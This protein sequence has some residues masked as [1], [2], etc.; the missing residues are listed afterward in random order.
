MLGAI[1]GDIV[2]SRYEARDS[3]MLSKDFPLFDS[4]CRFTDDTVMTLATAEA[5]IAG[6]DDEGQKS[7]EMKFVSDVYKKW[8]KKFPDR[9]YGIRTRMWY[10]S[11]DIIS[12]KPSFANGAAMRIS[13]AAWF[14]GTLK[15]TQAKAKLLSEITH[16]A[17]GVKGAQAIASAVFMAI[18]RDG[19]D[20]PYEKGRSTEED[21][22]DYIE[23]TYG[24]NLSI[25]LSDANKVYRHLE[26]RRS[27]AAKS[28]PAAILA[29]LHGAD[30]EDVIRTAVSLGG[31]SDTIAAMAGSIAEAYFGIPE[32]IQKH[33]CDYMSPDLY[34]RVLVFEREK[35]RF[36]S[37]KYLTARN[38]ANKVYAM[39]R[40]H[41]RIT[42]FGPSGW[43]NYFDYE[44][45][46]DKHDERNFW[47]DVVYWTNYLYRCNSINKR[48]RLNEEFE[49][50]S[51]LKILP[52]TAGAYPYFDNY[53]TNEHGLPEG[54]VYSDK[55]FELI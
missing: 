24:Y 10:N 14:S 20:Y 55:L 49:Y 37:G 8:C 22:K 15:E 52:I 17:E 1:I 45:S 34:E 25:S 32:N 42:D 13:P 16:D 26:P 36:N 33:I 4:N 48:A 6:F 30:F 11:D 19:E 27:Q 28:V 50:F 23:T 2:G 46:K 38:A 54:M 40:D 51:C 12:S 3:N 47:S 5:C 9:G 31:D 44:D 7:E 53:P 18:E 21:I 39:N 43:Q 41:S 35:T 29:F